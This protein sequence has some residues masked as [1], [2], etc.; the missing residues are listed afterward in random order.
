MR[1]AVGQNVRWLWSLAVLLG[2]VRWAEAGP[3][4]PNAFALSGTG[5]FPTLAGTYTINTSGIPTISR[6]GGTTISGQI[7]SDAP[8]HE[9]AVFDFNA[10]TIGSSETFN[11]SGTLPLVLLSRGDASIAGTVNVSASGVVGGPGGGGGGGTT[12][13]P[14]A[15]SYLFAGGSGGGFGGAGGASGA[16]IFLTGAG[17]P[18]TPLPPPVPSLPG[19]HAYGDLTVSLQGGSAGGTGAGAGGGAIEIGAV[20]ALTLN[21]GSI[22]ANGASEQIILGGGSGGGIFLHGATVSLDGSL[23]ANGGNGGAG[24]VVGGPGGGEG[25][26]GGGGGGGRILIEYGSSISFAG[27]DITGFGGIGGNDYEGFNGPGVSGGANGTLTYGPYG[28][29]FTTTV[30]PEP[31]SLVPGAIAVA[32]AMGFRWAARSR[33]RFRPSQPGRDPHV[34]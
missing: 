10:I 18:G 5:A 12:L 8:G 34:E 21:G 13:G 1:Y 11:A 15:G 7:Y 28:G 26:G 3:L 2:A 9:L 4:D 33:N 27:A 31:P 22:L 17:P 24:I 20:G 6:P 29:P 23:A 19:G 25:G 14:G 30:L 32:I 16:F